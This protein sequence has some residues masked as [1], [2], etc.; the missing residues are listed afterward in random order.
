MYF[1]RDIHRDLRDKTGVGWEKEYLRKDYKE[2]RNR[3]SA[4]SGKSYSNTQHQLS[5]SMSP[6]LLYSHILWCLISTLSWETNSVFLDCRWV[7]QDGHGGEKSKFY[8]SHSSVS[9]P[10]ILLRST[11]QEYFDIHFSKNKRLSS[12]CLLQVSADFSLF[13]LNSLMIASLSFLHVWAILFSLFFCVNFPFH[14]SH[15]V[16]PGVE[17]HPLYK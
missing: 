2:S 4:F 16:W 5:T 3:L 13:R 1:P 17:I 14:F 10:P 15:Q 9:A 12:L 11:S 7:G 8:F 6:L